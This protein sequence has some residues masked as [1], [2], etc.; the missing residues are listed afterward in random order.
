MAAPRINVRFTVAYDGRAFHGWQ[1]HE[2]VPTIQGALEAAL[3][4][5]C[6]APVEVRGA[7]RTDRGAHAQG[8]VAS[9]RLPEEVD[10][11]RLQAAVQAA[12]PEGISVRDVRATS[13]EFHA[14]MS[15][16]GKRYVY[17]IH[18]QE[19]LPAEAQGRVWHVPGALDV[20]A[21]RACL[22]IFIGEQDFASFATKANHARKSTVRTVSSFT[23]EHD[24]PRIILR[25]EA[26]GFL[27]K[28]VRNLVRAIT[29]VG[30]GRWTVERLR[31]ILA[32]RDRQAA[33]GTA[34]ASGLC[35]EEV[36]YAEDP[37]P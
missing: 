5:V 20:E 24:A 2:G 27:Y 33:P 21:M 17:T 1:R 22:E 9:A 25:I 6:D 10:V 34:P 14:R 36:F 16:I 37:A 7:G 28:M 11:E 19:D 15:A 30:E 23:L 35:L 13:R 26:D 12:L 8:Q 4:K 29:K 32:A 3:C 18:N 31:E